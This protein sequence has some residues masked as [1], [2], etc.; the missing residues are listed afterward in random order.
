MNSTSRVL[1]DDELA[2]SRPS[3]GA[4]VARPLRRKLP[5]RQRHVRPRTVR[6]RV[7][8]R[9]PEGVHEREAYQRG[10]AEGTAIGKEQAARESAAGARPACAALWRN[11]SSLR[12]ANPARRRKGS[13][14]AVDRDRP[15]RAASRIDARSGVDRRA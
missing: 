3:G 11:L 14:Q 7:L 4:T 9:L 6:P 10:F 5:I 12:S 8:S 2:R 15:P 1:R 13:A